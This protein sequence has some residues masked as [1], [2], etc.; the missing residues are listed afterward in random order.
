MRRKVAER[1]KSSG[2]PAWLPRWPALLS[3]FPVLTI[4]LTLIG[5][6][7]DLAYLEAFG[8]SPKMLGHGP[9]DFLLRATY[10]LLP[11]IDKSSTL[12]ELLSTT[13][14]LTQIWMATEWMRYTGAAVALALV[15]LAISAKEFAGTTPFRSQLLTRNRD[16][17]HWL[18]AQASHA[19]EGVSKPWRF[20][21]GS[22]TMGWLA[23]PVTAYLL[24]A[25][26]WVAGSLV[27][28]A[29]TA[30]PI[31]GITGGRVYARELVIDPAHCAQKS[32]DGQ[33][34]RDGATCVR[35]LKDGKELARGRLI[36][37]TN[38][39]VW[40][41]RKRPWTVTSIPLDGAVV[42]YTD[43]EPPS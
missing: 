7:Y 13:K 22:A 8:L 15:L 26:V 4:I 42:E 28:L 27:L 37:Q 20:L 2:W 14:G 21:L 41:L 34:I 16:R 10:G 36:D 29:L 6:G 23:P 18:K 43:G 9:L 25:A 19:F 12:K 40:L 35:V 17:A 33:R 11:L 32:S 1:R 30:A 39:R 38:N 31:V 5:Y 24:G 3:V